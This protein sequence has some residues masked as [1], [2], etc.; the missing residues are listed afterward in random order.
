MTTEN[1]GQKQDGVKFYHQYKNMAYHIAFSFT[2]EEKSAEQVVAEVMGIF[3]ECGIF[4][5]EL[6]REERK[7]LLVLV[8]RHRAL[9]ASRA[10]RNNGESCHDVH[11][12]MPSLIG[13]AEVSVYGEQIA[14]IPERDR[15]VLQLSLLFALSDDR[16][17]HLLRMKRNAVNARRTRALAFIADQNSLSDEARAS[18]LENS[19]FRTALH[20]WLKSHINSVEAVSHM[21]THVFAPETE[22]CILSALQGR[23]V[24]KR[25]IN[26]IARLGE[27]QNRILYLVAALVLCV[28][29]ILTF[30]RF[31]GGRGHQKFEIQNSEIS[32]DASEASSEEIVT[33]IRQVKRAH[34]AFYKD[35]I[36]FLDEKN[37]VLYE[38]KIGADVRPVINLKEAI[39]NAYGIEH[40]GYQD[41]RIYL[42]FVNGKGGHISGNPI[43]LTMEQYWAKAWFKNQDDQPATSQVRVD[44]VEYQFQK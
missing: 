19:S 29:L 27:S 36:L 28:I 30:M 17:S 1:E 2:H 11:I 44:G 13:D 9:V 33:E 31:F 5:S 41:G 12:P 14:R 39:T 18:L 24:Y 6:S 35:R 4:E 10:L 21:D 25:A 23:P 16:I 43:Q 37:G 40:I 26:G 42:A 22:E 15:I 7:G 20:L 8:T 32:S 34:A 3:Q 38:A